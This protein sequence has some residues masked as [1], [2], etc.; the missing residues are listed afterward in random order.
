MFN[1]ALINISC[2]AAGIMESQNIHIHKM[3][4]GQPGI[5]DLT[6]QTLPICL[7]T[8][9]C[10]I[11]YTIA[12]SIIASGELVSGTGFTNRFPPLLHIPGGNPQIDVSDLAK[13]A[14]QIVADLIQIFGTGY[15]PRVRLRSTTPGKL[16]LNTKN[17]E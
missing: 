4:I 2:Q 1:H 8:V 6:E 17:T 7:G 11:D 3:D 12:I 13:M 14:I 9:D 16:R 15:L 10:Q 5:T